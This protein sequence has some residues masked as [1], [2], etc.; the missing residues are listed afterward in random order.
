MSAATSPARPLRVVQVGAGAMGRVWLRTLTASEDV[1]LVGVADLDVER[2]RA[3][4]RAA[5]ADDAK[6]GVSLGDLLADTAP[7]AVVNV[8]VPAAHSDVNIEALFAGIPVLCEK[9]AAPTLAEAVVQVAAA[10]ATGRLLMVS[11]SRRYY[12]A[13]EE[14]R[15]RIAELGTPGLLTTGFFRGERFGG[16]RDV[17]EQPLLVDMAIHPFD[18]ARHLLGAEPI[19]VMCETWNPAWSWY[20]GDASATA[21]FLFDGGTRYVYTASWCAEG[22]E[23]P[24]NGQWRATGPGGSVTW[25]GEHRVTSSTGGPSDVPPGTHEEIAGALAEFV[26]ALRTGAESSGAIAR[27]I[28]SLAMV[29]AAV[30]SA[31]SGARVHIGELLDQAHR[32]ALALP[33]RDE[34]RARLEASAPPPG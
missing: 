14:Y 12:A 30:R 32:D 8:T 6:V 29:E 34:I 18:A 5:G 22:L 11:Q 19:S 27:N 16:F 2:A 3:A 33:V 28:R 23:T 4:V 25:D 21:T 1:D 7:D 20:H 31:E 26:A 9:P 15:R 13:L 10:E 24:W 17:M